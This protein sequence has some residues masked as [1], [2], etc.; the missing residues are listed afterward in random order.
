MCVWLSAFT[1]EPWE[2]LRLLDLQ[3]SIILH[4]D[5][6]LVTPS[7]ANMAGCRF[8]TS[9]RN[10]GRVWNAEHPTLAEVLT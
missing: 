5:P 7:E 10:C 6:V 2:R 8:D 4:G 3:C 9:A 1:P